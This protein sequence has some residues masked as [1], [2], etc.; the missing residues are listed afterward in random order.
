MSRFVDLVRQYDL[1]IYRTLHVRAYRE[2]LAV[3][4]AFRKCEEKETGGEVE[5]FF[6]ESVTVM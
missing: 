4:Y 3:D 6:L 2:D 5:G 1:P